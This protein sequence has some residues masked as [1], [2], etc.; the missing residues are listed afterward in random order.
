MDQRR[1]DITAGHRSAGFV[2]GYPGSPLAG[3][4]VELSRQAALLGALDIVHQPALNEELAATAVAGSQLASLRPGRRVEGVSALWYAK[5]PGLDR[6]GDA[7]R[8][9][10]LMGTA[11]RGGV[12]VCVGDDPQAKSSSV[13]STSE[14][15][16]Y[17]LGL[18]VLAPSDPQDL[19]DLG[20][21]GYA[22]SRASGLWVGMRIPATV[23]DAVQNIEVGPCRVSPRLPEVLVDGRPFVHRPTAQLLGAT[24]IALERT[25]YGPRLEM[26]RHYAADNALDRI[27]CRGSDDV[28]GVVAAGPAYLSVRHALGRLGLDEAG[29]QHAGVRLFKVA[30]PYPLNASTVRGFADGL[31]EIVVV[32]DKRGFLEMLVKEA[33]YG[34]T[35]APAVVGKHDEVGRELIAQTG[36]VDPDALAPVLAT[37]LLRYRDIPAVRQA[38]AA[39]SEARSTDGP[40][41]F[42]RGAY[43]C[44]G[45]PH[46]TG[47]KVPQDAVV[48]SGSGCHGLAIQM[49]PRQTG[50]VVG[51]FQMG[52][53]GAMW[54]G[55][56]PFVEGGHFFQNVGDGTF[57]HSASQSVR[58]SVAAGVDITY[59][60]LRNSVVAMTGGQPIPGGRSLADLCRLLLAE[61]A[62]QIIV[63]TDDRNRPEY[64]DLPPS[65]QVW[66]RSRIL[67][68]QEV[69]AGVRGVTVLIYDQECAVERQ[70][71]DRRTGVTR[72]R[73][74]FVNPLLCDGCGDCGAKSNCVAVRPV[75]SE[76]GLRTEIH[77][78]S[79]TLD[80]ACLDADCPAIVTVEPVRT[81][82]PGR[83][84]VTLDAD[85][86]P[87]P[88]ATAY[89][90][91]TVRITGV[92]GT[93]IVTTARIISA[94][95]H[96]SDLSV[97]GLDQ[98]GIAQKGGSVCSDL[99]IAT[100][101]S[102]DT[103]RIAAGECDLYLGSDLLVAAD[104][105]HLAAASPER[106]VAVMSLDSAPTGREV[107]DR[108]IVPPDL[109]ALRARIE[110]RTRA[111][112]SIWVD[113]QALSR[114]RFGSDT[115]ANIVLLGAA[116]QTGALPLDP[117]RIEAAIRQVGVA[118]D[119]NVQAF[120]LGRSLVVTP[121]VARRSTRDSDV[122]PPRSDPTVAAMVG[123]VGA[124]PESELARIV[125]T[126][127]EDLVAY[128]DHAYARRYAQIVAKCRA[129]EAAGCG[130]DDGPFAR[131]VA[132]QLHRVMAYRDEYEVARLH[133]SPAL[134]AQID[135]HF[136]PGG[137]VR[138]HLR[139]P[140]LHGAGLARKV[141]VGRGAST[142]FAMLSSLR[143]L[144]GT[145][146][147][148]FGHS[149]LRQ[150][151]RALRDTYMG[152]VVDLC[153]T[154]DADSHARAIDIAELPDSIRGYG[155]VKETAIRRF[156]QRLDELDSDVSVPVG[157]QQAS[158]AGRTPGAPSN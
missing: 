44:A 147:D 47:T 49:D 86:I 104:P 69:L 51:R 29:L 25:L 64:A 94:A 141:P 2:T 18:P 78:E 39:D 108:S 57:A 9:G 3:Y 38:V 107:A 46:N 132:V 116:C 61:G 23:A 117:T 106:T 105:R 89:T 58:A 92:G 143:H 90:T 74:V 62:R 40:F 60:L 93:G 70:R 55:M 148:P 95:A 149:E 103:H 83:R 122:A 101:P 22:L 11:P 42:V 14:P 153:S 65:V 87:A 137:R 13:P 111:A 79:C 126:K 158:I 5:A 52:G 154:L 102:E 133:G 130:D 135:S 53:E 134:R 152:L 68:A 110:H 120:R 97:R 56:A 20:L 31:R 43:F 24:L 145:P 54:N 77:Q 85:A 155:A 114:E 123:L 150:L 72:R 118:P 67:A 84:E 37:R 6:A 121:E 151:E 27:T 125:A 45:C 81:F 157:T 124:S 75:R 119:T 28:L 8:H 15:T 146:F 48:G 112:G 156:R 99:R 82:E 76:H 19:L 131:T 21:H 144:R 50:D 88:R 109:S 59:K 113:A 36:E 142:A 35:G 10:N 128:Q 115:Y 16:L 127:I 17:G 66:D 12:L 73:R 139:P 98:T 91:F 1:A 140:L 4:D 7:V 100:T 33:L 138:Y 63:T 71:R 41:P 26:A 136:G 129:A 96:A 30:M 32:E 80:Y 34:M